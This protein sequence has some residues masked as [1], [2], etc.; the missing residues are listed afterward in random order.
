[1]EGNNNNEDELAESEY[2]LRLEKILLPLARIY[3][4]ADAES[5]E[6]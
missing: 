1:M 2:L 5:R 6:K 3:E 4:S